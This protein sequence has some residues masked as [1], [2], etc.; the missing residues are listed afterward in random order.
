MRFA[1]AGSSIN[2]KADYTTNKNITSQSGRA[3]F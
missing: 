2:A 1:G 3:A